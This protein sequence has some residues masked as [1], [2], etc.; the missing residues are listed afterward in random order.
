MDTLLCE[1]SEHCSL[2]VLW[3][4]WRGTEQVHGREIHW[5]K[6]NQHISTSSI[7]EH[8]HWECIRD[9][10]SAIYVLTISV[11]LLT[12]FLLAFPH[13]NTSIRDKE[14]KWKKEAKKKG[15]KEKKKKRPGRKK[16]RNSESQRKNYWIY[17]PSKVFR[18]LVDITKEC[19]AH[20]SKRM[21]I[22]KLLASSNWSFL[23]LG[24][25]CRLCRTGVPQVGK[26]LDGY[27]TKGEGES[28]AWASS[29]VFQQSEK[30]GGCTCVRVC[31]ALQARHWCPWICSPKK[32]LRL[33]M[34]PS[35]VALLLHD[36]NLCCLGSD[37]IMLPFSS[38][39]LLQPV[40]F[41]FP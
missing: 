8:K 25:G 29:K 13:K 1:T 26:T 17:Y 6:H 28:A 9:Y 21:W 38:N 32:T 19:F 34:Y 14:K 15:Q 40:W 41:S 4:G 30:Q 27:R 5:E 39:S 31:C 2:P 33:Q 7:C 20:Q 11:H 36:A 12:L 3:H 37:K 35:A 16:G 10:Y 22:Q 24:L 18:G 23:L